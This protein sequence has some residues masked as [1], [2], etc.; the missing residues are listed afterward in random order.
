MMTELGNSL[1]AVSVAVITMLVIGFAFSAIQPIYEL[2]FLSALSDGPVSPEEVGKLLFWP[3]MAFVPI[4]TVITFGLGGFVA[5]RLA[6]AATVNHALVASSIPLV[7]T[8]IVVLNEPEPE[9]VRIG[10]VSVVGIA[11]ATAASRLGGRGMTDRQWPRTASR[12]V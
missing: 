2:N 7:L 9:L 3:A 12:E 6:D 4:S 11:A 1:K 5:G 10:L 8:W